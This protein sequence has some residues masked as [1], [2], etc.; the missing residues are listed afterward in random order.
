MTDSE[1]HDLVNQRY[2]AIEDAIDT[3]DSDDVD[4]DCQVNS[5]ILTLTFENGS[6]IIINKQEPLHQIWVATR[7]NGYHFDYKNNQWIDNREGHELLALL[8][9]ACSK[10]AG[11]PV[12]LS[13]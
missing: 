6:K 4:I 11:A 7:E 13:A 2:L 1:F 8:S 9:Q 5:G 3:L 12:T 10:Q